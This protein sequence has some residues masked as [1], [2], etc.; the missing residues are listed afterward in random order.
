V[1]KAR[2]AAATDPKRKK[3]LV[4][5]LKAQKKVSALRKKLLAAPKAKKAA[6]KA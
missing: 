6:I 3:V 4:A 5:Q 2:I 1:I